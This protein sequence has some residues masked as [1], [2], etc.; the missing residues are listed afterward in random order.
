[1]PYLKISMSVDSANL[2]TSSISCGHPSMTALGGFVQSLAHKSGYSFDFAIPFVSGVSVDSGIPLPARSTFAHVGDA[3]NLTQGAAKNATLKVIGNFQGGVAL[4]FAY[5]EEDA[6][7]FER[8]VYA[9]GFAS[10]IVRHAKVELLASLPELKSSFRSGSFA[11]GMYD[12]SLMPIE[13]LTFKRSQV[14]SERPFDALDL[15]I[16]SQISLEKNRIKKR[17]MPDVCLINQVGY[18][19]LSSQMQGKNL[20][21]GKGYFAE[22]LMAITALLPM[23]RV[24]NEELI[25]CVSWRYSTEGNAYFLKPISFYTPQQL[26]TEN[27]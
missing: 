25:D 21:S 9:G 6:K 3:D 10:G 23:Q 11:Y 15:A 12:P 18:V 19:P 1:M 7:R 26:E 14:L 20:R 5:G 22:P 27:V 4:E 16:M 2:S 17:L 24:L 13:G 8:L